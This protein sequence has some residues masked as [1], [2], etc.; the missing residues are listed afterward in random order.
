MD[1]LTASPL[2]SAPPQD[3]AR[4]ARRALCTALLLAGAA[5]LPLLQGCAGPG[6]D[7]R[8]QP[9]R[10]TGAEIIAW[11]GEPKRAWA[12]ADGGRTLEYSSQPFGQ[13]CWLVRLDDQDRV[14]RVWDGLAPDSLA[15]IVPG[16]SAQ[17]VSRRLGLERS[18][19][20]FRLSGEDV[21]DWN[22]APD[23]GGYPVRFNVHFKDGVVLRTSRSLVFPDRL[24][25]FER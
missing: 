7:A 17:Q 13:T 14:Q 15:A 19:V 22:V 10:S 20:F 12:E 6:R 4:T 16:L 25:P 9:G 18:R 1:A 2:P 24:F 5:P 8:L 21:W 11:W 23:P 3:G